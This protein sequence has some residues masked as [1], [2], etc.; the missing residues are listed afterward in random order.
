MADLDSTRYPDVVDPELVGTYPALAHAGGGFVWD[1][2]LEYRVWCHPERGAPDLEDGSD[3]YYAFATYAEASAFSQAT[4]GAEEPL[5]LIRQLE[6]IDEPNPGQYRHVKEPRITEC[7][8]SSFCA[9]GGRR[10]LFP[11][12]SHRTRLQTGWTSSAVWPIGMPE[13]CRK[14]KQQ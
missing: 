3:S 4:I 1:E 11:T 14:L 9:P 12:S 13:G 6:H 10:I 2:V 8:R 7:P 5:A